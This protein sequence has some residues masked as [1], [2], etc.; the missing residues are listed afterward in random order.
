M[1][2]SGNGGSRSRNSSTSRSRSGSRNMGNHVIIAVVVKTVQSTL[3]IKASVLNATGWVLWILS[4]C[5]IQIEVFDRIKPPVFHVVT[6]PSHGDADAGLFPVISVVLTRWFG[7]TWAWAQS[8]EGQ[9]IALSIRLG[10]SSRPLDFS[11]SISQLRCMRIPKV[12]IVDLHQ[13]ISRLSWASM[14]SIPSRIH[15]TRYRFAQ[16][17]SFHCPDSTTG[18]WRCVCFVW[19]FAF[20]PHDFSFFLSASKLTKKYGQWT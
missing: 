17:V 14:F 19:S 20:A 4:H 11:S 13:G 18:L 12:D 15:S 6:A 9:R 2:P 5:A 16:D 1:S 3:F 7:S 10:W 8:V